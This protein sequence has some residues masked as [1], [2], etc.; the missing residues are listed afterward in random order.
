[1]L[2]KLGSLFAS[3]IFTDDEAKTRNASV[4]NTLLLSLILGLMLIGFVVQFK[5][6]YVFILLLILTIAV[7]LIMHR[8]HVRLASFFIVAGLSILF[9]FIVP[10]TGG[11]RAVTY[12]GFLV[13][14]LLSGLLLGRRAAI[15]IA[16][17]APLLG[18]T[19]LG[20]D[21]LGLWKAP[22][23]TASDL[24]IWISFTAY[25]LVTAAVLALALQLI[26]EGFRK[27]QTA[28]AERMHAEEREVNRR[29]M[30]EKV[31]QIGKTVT[32]TSPDLHTTL[33]R[34]RD[35]VRYGLDFD[36]VG[37]F[38]YNSVDNTMEGTYGTDRTGENI[39]AWDVKF[40]LDTQSIFARVL[41]RSD[42][43][44][45]TK[46]YAVEFDLPPGH[47]MLGVKYYAAIAVW[48]GEKP[49]A[50]IS[51]DQL[52]SGR[53][54]SDEQLEALRLFAGYAGLA[55]QNAR[56]NSELENRVK[57]REKII[58]ELEMRNSEME[59][60]TYTASHDLKSPLVTIKG[61]LGMLKKDISKQQFDRADHDMDRINNAAEKMEI[62]LSDLLELSRIGR[63]VNPSEKIDLVKL[64]FEAL[65][66]L[67]GRFQR[68]DITINISPD[69]PIVYGDQIR[70]REVFENLIDNAAK[71]MGDQPHQL[72]EIGKRENEAETIIYIKDNGIGIE[73]K[74]HTKIFGLF[75]KLKADSEG[76]GIGLAIVKRIIE[77]HGGKIWVESEGPEKGSTFCFTLPNSSLSD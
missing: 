33:L 77:V 23:S 46:D 42:G 16:L 52:V 72:I 25:F 18:A 27:A 69:L 73:S 54:I 22:A 10:T 70:L 68:H 39:E 66:M 8:G 57:E 56:L 28:L 24:A 20:L 5:R 59:R 13:V 38:L 60:F 32:E 2:N 74:Y 3:P 26:D 61:F 50:I 17:F 29:I 76:T 63:V 15:A 30:M 12:G 31:I 9:T 40:E 43:W 58:R 14:I 1:M 67:D 34:I 62:L 7:W 71:Y 11:V 36:R 49:M 19:M 45:S 51:V 47:D 41:S 21:A 6:P 37:L 48:A 75:E 53:S 64:A 4:L 55:I 65:E 35:S 44:Y